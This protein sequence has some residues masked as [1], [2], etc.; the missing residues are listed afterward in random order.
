[1]RLQAEFD[2]ARTNLA[3]AK[4]HYATMLNSAAALTGLTVK[5]LQAPVRVAG[6]AEPQPKWRSIG[7]L[8]FR[9]KIAA[10]V[11]TI[12]V[13]NGGWAETGSLVLNTVCPHCVRF[14][15]TAPQSD[16]QRFCD[17]QQSRIVPPQGGSIGLQDAMSGELKLG[18]QGQAD[19]RTL[20]LFVTPTELKHWA[21]P[22]VSAFLEIYVDGS[23]ERVLAIPRRCVV[24]DGLVDVFFRRDPADP[25]RVIR[26]EADLGA[27]DGRWVAVASGVKEGDEIVLQG[28]YELKLATSHQTTKGGHFCGDGTFHTEPH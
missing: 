11:D 28:A 5:D 8:T 10:V 6:E 27:N 23:D 14:H 16:I 13:T 15:A 21:R 4:M 19:Q 2:A 1:V 3:T 22:G 9:A 7:Y 18:F 24:R 26:V 12:G 20:P 25:N 17:G